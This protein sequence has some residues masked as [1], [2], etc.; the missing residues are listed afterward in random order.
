MTAPA[1]HRARDHLHAVGRRYAAAWSLADNMRVDSDWPA[2]CFLPMPGWAVVQA[3]G[4]GLHPS[5]TVH[6]PAAVLDVGRL[7]TLGAWR[8][9]QGIYRFDPDVYAAVADTPMDN[10]LPADVLTRMPEWSIYLETPGMHYG[11]RELAGAWVHLDYG[12]RTGQTKLRVLLDAGLALEDLIP[13][14]AP[15][16]GSLKQSI[17]A[18]MMESALRHGQHGLPMQDPR[19]AS[20]DIAAA[21]GP[22]V[23][24]LLYVC[25]AGADITRGG[26]PAQP[27]HPVPQRTRRHGEKLF[28]ADGPRQWDVGVRL[29][30]ALRRA[31]AAE[32][33][34]ADG[35]AGPR[36]HI[37]R[38]H[39]HGF[40]SGPIKQGD[41]TPIPATARPLDVRWMPPIAVN[42]ADLDAMPATIRPVP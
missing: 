25:S 15:L 21:L 32:H 34:G 6:D 22:I 12:T 42:V 1:S 27:S 19:R 9:T 5:Q 7:A 17:D 35:H 16:Q 13:L 26:V 41:G 18:A 30:A 8:M 39:W 33:A 20:A 14:G 29:G 11:G 23:S 37:R 40:R 4:V 10:D 31:Y 24:L 38:A 36:A 3:K 28:A 2:W